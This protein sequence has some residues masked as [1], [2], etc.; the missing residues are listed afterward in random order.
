MQRRQKN[1]LQYAECAELQ[2]IT[3]KIY[4]NSSVYTY[5]FF[6]SFNFCC[7]S[8]CLI[9][10]KL[11]LTVWLYK[12]PLCFIFYL[13]VLQPLCWRCV[14]CVIHHERDAR[15]EQ[16]HVY[17]AWTSNNRVISLGKLCCCL[18]PQC[19]ALCTCCSGFPITTKWCC[20][21]MWKRCGVHPSQKERAVRCK[22][23]GD[24]VATSPLALR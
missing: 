21:R 2:K 12:C 19:K 4:S 22:K 6:K 20:D 16:H 18:L 13:L 3:I 9:W 24:V 23:G 7:C 14:K 1:W 5:L 11:R 8:F 15:K 17:V 10:K